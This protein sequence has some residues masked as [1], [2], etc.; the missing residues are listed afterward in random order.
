MF[1]CCNNKYIYLI[2]KNLFKMKHL[3]RIISLKTITFLMLT[4]FIT[5]CGSKK[6]M[7]Q[8]PKD[9]I[10]QN[11]PCT[12][13]DYFSNATFFKA[14][15]VGESLDQMTARKKAFAT[16]RQLLAT[17]IESTIKIVSDNYV[18]SN[19]V[20]NTEEVLEKFE[21]LSRTVVNRNLRRI[22]QICE[23]ATKSSSS[24]KYKYYIAIETSVNDIKS[25]LFKTLDQDQ[26]LKVDYNYQKFKEIFE[27][28]IN[29]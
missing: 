13:S 29:Q 15:A 11:L 28:E 6:N 20:N 7:L 24:G 3:Q 26:S 12:G 17:N 22:K 23:K 21:N 5:S 14:T 9:E 18:K 27:K 8:V 19:E 16:A 25:D 2:N 4:T 1:C 10:V